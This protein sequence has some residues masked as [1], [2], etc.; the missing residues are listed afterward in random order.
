MNLDT[1]LWQFLA[2]YPY[3]VPTVGGML[4]SI[5][6]IYLGGRHVV[7]RIGRHRRVA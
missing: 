2:R 1:L 6:L 5:Y 4:G 3:Y 7:R